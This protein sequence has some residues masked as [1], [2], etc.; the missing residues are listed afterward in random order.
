MARE[1][2]AYL[3]LCKSDRRKKL[4][5]KIKNKYPQIRIVDI[6]CSGRFNP[7]YV[8]KL[9]SKEVDGILL[10]GCDP[11]DCQYREGNLFA[12]RRF[13][14]AKKTL[15][16]FGLDEERFQII[17]HKVNEINPVLLEIDKFINE[18]DSLNEMERGV[19]KK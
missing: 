9:L 15:S 11:A 16:G 3:F 6:V 14:L 1:G 5:D 8:F 7:A 4:I 2:I 13:Y 19:E 12:E 17:W 18:L 10:L